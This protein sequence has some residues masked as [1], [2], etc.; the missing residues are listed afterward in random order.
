M[1]AFVASRASLCSIGVQ[2]A[3]AQRGTT[4]STAASGESLYSR[5][6]GYDAIAAVV[7]DL[8]PRLQEDL[9][10]RRF[11]T[12]PRSNDTN[13]R[14]RQLTVDFIAAAA[15]GPTFYL[16]RDMKT[17]HQGMGI[18]KSDYAAFERHLAATVEKF[19]VPSRERDEVMNFISKLES[20]I[21][22]G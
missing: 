8:L 17:S 4:V 16:G 1:R 20:E 19:N 6:G 11:F 7:D 18:N 14:E 13:K 10:L 3:R 21:L 5:L 12:S 15:G 2:G 22:E 9:L